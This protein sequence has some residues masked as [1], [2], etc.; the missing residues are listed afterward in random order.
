M[1]HKLVALHLSDYKCK[2]FT[3]ILL[4]STNYHLQTKNILLQFLL[5]PY[6]LVVLI[7]LL[8]NFLP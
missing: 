1:L 7:V 2:S 8:C 4:N 5:V 6:Q 3:F